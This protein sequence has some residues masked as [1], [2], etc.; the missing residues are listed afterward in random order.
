[1]SVDTESAGK[2]PELRSKCQWEEL[3]RGAALATDLQR[4]LEGSPS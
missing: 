3:I 2:L 1:M 4:N